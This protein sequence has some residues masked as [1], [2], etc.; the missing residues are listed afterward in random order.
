M[1]ASAADQQAQ[2]A[3][4][5]SGFMPFPSARCW[6]SAAWCRRLT[7]SSRIPPPHLHHH[8][9]RPGPGAHAL[10]RRPRLLLPARP[11]LGCARLPQGTPAPDADPR[12]DGILA[13]PAERLLP[14]RYSRCR[15]QRSY[16]RSLLAA[17]PDA[18]CACGVQSSARLSRVLA[19]TKTDA[20]RLIAL[21]CPPE[22]V[23]VS[24]NLKF[25]VRAAKE[26]EAT[27]L[28]KALARRAALRCCRQH[29]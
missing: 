1:P 19:Q 7:R 4:P 14:P 15:R 17:L 3:S 12:R 6:R 28:L 21:G 24:G 5:S 10:R 27:Q 16:L 25:D 20:E 2:T 29:A 23:S 9:H 22:L 18:A 13:Q 8:P 11:A 26:A